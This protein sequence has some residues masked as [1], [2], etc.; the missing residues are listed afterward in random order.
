VDPETG[1]LVGEP[2]AEKYWNRE[3]YAPGWEPS[4]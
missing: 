3:S 1:H 4:L 2:E